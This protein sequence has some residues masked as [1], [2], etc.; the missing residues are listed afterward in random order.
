[1]GLQVLVYI[2]MFP[3][4]LQI[5]MDFKGLLVFIKEKLHG[6]KIGSEFEV[7]IPNFQEGLSLVFIW[8]L[9]SYVNCKRWKSKKLFPIDR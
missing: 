1:M 6:L 7:V 3:W 8:T 4:E 2:F 5:E 9:H